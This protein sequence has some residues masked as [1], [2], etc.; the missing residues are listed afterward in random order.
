M[1]N[2]VLCNKVNIHK[3]VAEK[4]IDSCEYGFGRIQ[5]QE[6]VKHVFLDSAKTLV[7]L[8]R[9][10]ADPGNLITSG[11]NL[12]MNEFM[13]NGNYKQHLI[14]IVIPSFNILKKTI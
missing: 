1:I 12:R 13:I 3:V 6:S 4:L 9:D 2:K 14:G 5:A 11:K 7:F 10:M 8:T